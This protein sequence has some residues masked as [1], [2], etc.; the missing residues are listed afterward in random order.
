MPGET[1]TNA[2]CMEDGHE[3]LDALAL[4]LWLA[5]P[6]DVVLRESL[7]QRHSRHG[8]GRLRPER[9]ETLTRR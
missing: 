1:E 2:D 5:K 6:G 7:R 3:R 8:D 9:A 4:V